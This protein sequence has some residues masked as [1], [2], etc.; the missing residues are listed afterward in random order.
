MDTVPL[1]RARRVHVAPQSGAGRWEHIEM[2]L[3]T[4]IEAFDVVLRD[5]STVHLRPAQPAD[6][7]A[8][9]AMFGRL[10]TE[11]LYSRFFRIPKLP[12]SRRVRTAPRRS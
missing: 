2:T 1:T 3:P 6:E 12:T 10:S 9:R 8:V 5:G 11:S 4:A 7:T